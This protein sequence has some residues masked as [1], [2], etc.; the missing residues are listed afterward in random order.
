MSG[1]HS[2]TDVGTL[3][4]LLKVIGLL[5]AAA[6]I[7]AGM[8]AYHF[9]NRWSD[10]IALAESARDAYL[11]RWRPDMSM[12]L[13]NGFASVAIL[14][15]AVL[16]ATGYAASAYG[17]RKI[18]L[19]ALTHANAL[20]RAKA[21]TDALRRT[22]AE[23]DVRL[24]NALALRQTLRETEVRHLA[25]TAALRRELEQVQ[26]R[27]AVAISGETEA[28]LTAEIETLH[29]ASTQA[30]A[31]HAAETA[32]LRKA[33][34]LASSRRVAITESLRW[35]VRQ[36]EAKA[37][38]DIARLEEQLTGAERK[39]ASLQS[40]RR[41][42]LDEKYALIAALRPFAGQR[43][44][45]AA[46]D[47]DEDG[48]GFAAD[49]AEVFEA[50][51][52]QHPEVDYRRWDRDPVGVE[53][54]LNEADGRAGRVNTA[55]GALINIARKLSLTEGNTIYMAGEVPSGQVQVKIGKKL[56]R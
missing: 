21:E 17:H 1:W 8:I 29:R 39:L 36:T 42:S 24:T 46:I 41:L 3:H 40:K 47:G 2:L 31:R 51:G 49:F 13:H 5:A 14:G 28:R 54:T 30:A 7:S 56:L 9:W 18:E 27:R 35:E 23:R 43:V 15:I 25:E 45:I 16:L 12:T 32:E 48:K 44:V 11:P 37:A 22:M 10:L 6:M 4:A 33:L 50:A 19:A 55:V 38:K 52:W 20:A 34:E 53:I 26:S